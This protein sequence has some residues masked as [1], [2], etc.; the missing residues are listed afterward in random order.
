L[1]ADLTNAELDELAELLERTP[2]PLQPL[3]VVML[4]GYLAGVI[5][6]PRLVGVDEWLPP[7]FDLGRRPLPDEAGAAADDAWQAR[8]RA[9]IER[10]HAAINRELAEEGTFD[11]VL[12]DDEVPP[13]D[14]AALRDAWR[15]LSPPSRVLMPW[16]AGFQHAALVFPDLATLGDDAVQGALARLWRHLPAGSDQER[17]WRAALDRERPLPDLD[18]AIEDLVLTVAELWEL[19]EPMRYR[20][21]TV[22]REQPKVG[23]NDPC[24]CGSG[25]KFKHCH[26]G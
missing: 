9:L 15:E 24:P 14:D 2:A 19:T 18:T 1:K 17:A 5:V 16:V 11:P 25:R 21:S 22:R 12:H 8:S 3:D 10:R 6:Q 13:E 20:V 26:G 4:D 23:R 7:V